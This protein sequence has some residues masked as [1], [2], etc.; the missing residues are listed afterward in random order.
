MA[1]RQRQGKAPATVPPAEPARRPQR[2]AESTVERRHGALARR[3]RETGPIVET[4]DNPCQLLSEWILS[5]GELI[6]PMYV[7]RRHRYHREI[8]AEPVGADDRAVTT[9][10]DY[11]FACVG[12]ARTR[13]ASETQRPGRTRVPVQPSPRARLPVASKDD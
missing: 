10:V 12:F 9:A 5:L 1:K 2:E 4:L 3:E 7:R 13:E 11:E 6:A 8:L